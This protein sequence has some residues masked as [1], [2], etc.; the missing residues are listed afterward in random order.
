MFR[1][2]RLKDIAEEEADGINSVHG[3]DSGGLS[4]DHLEARPVVS[5]R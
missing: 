1:A 3:I 2:S 4:L 5:A